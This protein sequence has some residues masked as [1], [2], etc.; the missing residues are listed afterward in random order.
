MEGLQALLAVSVLAAA[1]VTY[2]IRRAPR[3]PTDVKSD[4]GFR[5]IVFYLLG[6]LDGAT[7]RLRGD[8]RNNFV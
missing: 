8:L 1:L 3:T 2:G 5:E 6:A 4:P 7:P